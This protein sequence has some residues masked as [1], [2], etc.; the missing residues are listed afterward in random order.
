MSKIY[1]SIYASKAT[2]ISNLYHK[3]TQYSERVN[4]EPYKNS[5]DFHLT[6]RDIFNSNLDSQY[7]VYRR[8][9]Y[10]KYPELSEHQ[11]Y[12]AICTFSSLILKEAYHDVE[13]INF[14]IQNDKNG[15]F[16]LTAYMPIIND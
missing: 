10:F 13:I 3:L 6:K 5:L 14:K 15:L 11:L 12:I 16:R 8:V 1:I 9:Y 4:N 2:N 7:M